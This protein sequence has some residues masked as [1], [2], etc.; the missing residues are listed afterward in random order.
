MAN[1]P[2]GISE[3]AIYG[4]QGN[5]AFPGTAANKTAAQTKA[6]ADLNAHLLDQSGS[7]ITVSAVTIVAARS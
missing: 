3:E 6:I 5:I 1:M 7:A 4:S 2:V